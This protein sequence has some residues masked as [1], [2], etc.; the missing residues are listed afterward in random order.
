[1]EKGM[2]NSL[3]ITFWLLLVSMFLYTSL[4][5]ESIFLKNG[6]RLD[7]KIIQVGEDTVT[8]QL[9]QGGGPQ[10]IPTEQINLITYASTMLQGVKIGMETGQ[11]SFIY[12]KNGEIVKGRIT[13][14]TSQF[15]TL[16]SLS[17]HGVLQIPT[18]EV[19]MITSTQSQMKM[20]QRKGIGYQQS[21][22]TLTSD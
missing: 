3:R 17:G 16:E 12:L 15:L 11:A 10:N 5:A 13:Q 1:M 8:I 18:N 9:S 19:N 2:K 20:N 14:Y 22:S 6:E 7:G 21:K 4:S